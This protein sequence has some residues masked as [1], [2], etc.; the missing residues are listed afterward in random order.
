MANPSR[1]RKN[2]PNWFACDLVLPREHEGL[3]LAGTQA[4]LTINGYCPFTLWVDG[5]E[6]F[7]EERIW[8]ATGPIVDPVFLPIEPGR[9]VRLVVRLVPTE[10]PA[11]G[12]L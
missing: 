10:L 7:R 4:M 12:S 9:R 2:R 6:Q 5:V 3:R 1:L 8:K 11:L